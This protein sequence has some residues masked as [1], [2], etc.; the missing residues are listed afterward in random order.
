[1]APPIDTFVDFEAVFRKQSLEVNGVMRGDDF[2]NAEAFV[3]DS[4]GSA[5]LLFAYATDGGQN[6][7][8]MTR[9]V[10]NNSGQLLGAFR[11]VVTLG[12]SGEFK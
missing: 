12:T 3:L 4:K 5:A 11:C 8:P 10:G 9:L 7:G 2:P 1:M 6:T